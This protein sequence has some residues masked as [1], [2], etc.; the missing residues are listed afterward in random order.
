[1]DSNTTIDELEKQ[2]LKTKHKLNTWERQFRKN[3][4]RQ[5]TTKDIGERPEISKRKPTV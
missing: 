1:M 3:H 2:V 5:V 4:G